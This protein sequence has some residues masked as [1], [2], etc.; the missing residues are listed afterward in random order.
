M[1]V[2]LV[3][4]ACGSGDSRTESAQ[5]ESPQ[6]G[7]SEALR[8]D[9]NAE[10]LEEVNSLAISNDGEVA[11]VQ[12]ASA[13]LLVFGSDGTRQ[14]SAGRSGRGPGEFVRPT[15]VGWRGDTLWAS[16]PSLKRLTFFHDGELVR[17]SIVSP[18]SVRRGDGSAQAL[19]YPMAVQSGDTLVGKILQ[20][21]GGYEVVRVADGQQV[22]LIVTVPPAPSREGVQL[23]SGGVGYLHVPYEEPRSYL[24]ISPSGENVAIADVDSSATSGHALRIRVYGPRGLQRF[25]TTLH[26]PAVPIS[27]RHVDSAVSATTSDPTKRELIRKLIPRFHPPILG[28]IISDQGDVW[29]GTEVGAAD[30]EWLKLDGDGRVVLRANLPRNTVPRLADDEQLWV[31]ERD[32]LGVESVVQ[33]KVSQATR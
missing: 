17:T 5:T 32:S 11:L 12:P 1:P 28:F 4:V 24:A 26:T 3:L 6:A 29:I 25:D 9:G 18:V 20:P 7:V 19:F 13:T 15:I 31:V 16:D 14:W 10:N 23:A 30:V 27:Q 21:G 8:L 22:D 33:L 2:C